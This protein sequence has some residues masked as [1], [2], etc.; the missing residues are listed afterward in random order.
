MGNKD[1]GSA[2]VFQELFQPLD[3]FHVQVVSGL[4]QQQDV[5]V[6]YQ[7]T[8]QQYAPLHAAGKAGER[9]V[10][11][12]IELGKHGVHPL[13]QLPGTAGLDLGAQLFE[14]GQ[15]LVVPVA[16][17][18]YQL[19]V[20]AEQGALLP[21]PFGHHEVHAVLLV[22]GHFLFQPGHTQPLGL[23][24]LAVIGLNFFG[25]DLHQGGLARPVTADQ[26][27]ALTHVDGQVDVV[28]Q[29]LLAI[30]ELNVAKGN[31]WH[32]L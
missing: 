6:L 2:K 15:Y 16:Q 18:V 3:G 13:G 9:H 23:L 11:I 28:Q 12:Q 17:M 30:A 7:S 32:T 19:G 5:R 14:A 29:R 27:Q 21:Q 20:F 10:T 25:Y 8:G 26:T 22:I 31:Q 1:Q 24:D 4:V